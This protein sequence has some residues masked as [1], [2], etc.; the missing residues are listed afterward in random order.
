MVSHL[1]VTVGGVSGAMPE[2]SAGLL[3]VL[4]E[5]RGLWREWERTRTQFVV[6]LA[7]I[8]RRRAAWDL[9]VRRA[10]R[11]VKPEAWWACHQRV[12]AGEVPVA[13]GGSGRS[14]QR[15]VRVT[16][17]AVL[18]LVARRDVDLRSLEAALADADAGLREATRRLVEVA[19]WDQVLRVIGWGAV[20]LADLIADRRIPPRT[21]ALLQRDG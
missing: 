14:V 19:G 12:A 7:R 18:D 2:R 16:T 6:A 3:G 8:A 1:V 13:A 17:P 21:A 9:Q 5:E 10:M 20:P 4:A 15:V 11:E